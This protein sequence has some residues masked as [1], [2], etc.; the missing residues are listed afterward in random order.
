[1]EAALG[2]VGGALALGGLF[3]GLAL[4]IWVASRAELQKRQLGQE[5]E[6]KE[7]E[8]EHA[9]RLKALERGVPLPDADLA[10]ARADTAWAVAAGLVAV[11]VP[12][13]MVG[14][15]VGATAI[16]LALAQPALHLPLVC[17]VWG[18]NGLT[19]I[20][21]LSLSLAALR[22]RTPRAA[23][24]ER[25]AP[26]KQPTG[27]PLLPALSERITTIENTGIDS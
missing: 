23:E 11:V 19:S 10:A 5:R 6:M 12:L 9:E 18:V 3:G 17:T 27:T 1:M 25:P 20:V 21:A 2:V 13:V 4:M 15:A 26:A 14:T 7:R 22:R 8:F 16:I 24:W